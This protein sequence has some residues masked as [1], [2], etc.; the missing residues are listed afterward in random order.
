[1]TTARRVRD[2]IVGAPPM[3][4]AAFHSAYRTLGGLFLPPEEARVGTLL[5]A[6]PELDRLTGVLAGLGCHPGWLRLLDRLASLDAAAY[7]RLAADHT[8]LFLSGSMALA[9]QPFESSHVPISEYDVGLVG[10]EVDARYRRAGL[11][12]NPGH[13]PDHVAVELEFCAALCHLEGDAEDER[14]AAR[15][16]SERRAFLED[17]LTRWLPSFVEALEAKR[18]GGLHAEAAA[19]ARDVVRDDLLVMGATGPPIATT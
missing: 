14:V 2:R 18:P 17:H 19:V 15:W 10:A 8:N 13:L 12:A 11:T 6:T 4:P 9:V 7:E 3:V 5:E 1:M 16:R